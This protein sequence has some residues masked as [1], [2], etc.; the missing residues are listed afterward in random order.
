MLPQLHH[1]TGKKW[2]L[3]FS[4]FNAT[5]VCSAQYKSV[6]PLAYAEDVDIIRRSICEVEAAFSKFAEKARS[7]GLAG[8]E[9]KT[10][11]LLSTAKDTSIGVSVKIYG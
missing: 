3:P 9:S 5:L 11:L 7:I 8:N 2:P 1:Q 4:G 6:M 10:K